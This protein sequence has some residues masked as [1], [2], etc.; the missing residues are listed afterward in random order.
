METDR[1]KYFCTIC[2]TGSLTKAADILGISHSGLSKAMSLLQDE[3][4]V[5]LFRPQGRGIE[6]TAEARTVYER[7]KQLLALVESLKSPSVQ[8]DSRVRIGLTEVLALSLASPL[9]RIF[10][11][12]FCEFHEMDSGEIESHLL[13]GKI[14]FGFSFVPYPQPELEYLKIRKVELGVFKREGAL[15]GMGLADLPF[16]VPIAALPSNPLSLKNRDGWP[17]TLERRT[18]FQVSSLKIALEIVD[19]GEAA[20]FIPRFLAKSLN[21]S[22]LPDH[23]IEE[24]AFPPGSF[25]KS[26]RDLFLVKKRSEEESP[27]MKLAAKAVRQVVP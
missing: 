22:R 19:A 6:P 15:K 10:T 20:I 9:A 12:D 11:E 26:Q 13:A 24:V 1:L 3:L 7:S 14:N 17:A 18:P 5:V 23:R 16:V 2:E 8:T 4:E 25:K 27:A 21:R